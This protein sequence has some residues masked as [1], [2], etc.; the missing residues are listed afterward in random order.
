MNRPVGFYREG[1]KIRP[2][3]K[4]KARKTRVVK[5]V[6]P[7]PAPEAIPRS[8]IIRLGLTSGNCGKYA[9]ALN[10]VNANKGKLIAVVEENEP[11]YFSHVAL[12]IK[13]RFYDA[14]GEITIEQLKEYGFDEDYPDQEIEVV[15][16]PESSVLKGTGSMF[17]P[18]V[19]VRELEEL[20]NGLRCS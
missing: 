4:K 6:V 9:I 13:G 18:E 14:T 17:A 1:G 15:Y 20:I 16:V 3:T 10:N 8:E 12:E 7:A 5:K 2:I 19:S 11:E